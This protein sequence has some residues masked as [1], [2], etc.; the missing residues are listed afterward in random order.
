MDVKIRWQI[1]WSIWRWLW[2]KCDGEYGGQYGCDSVHVNPGSEFARA[3]FQ[4][5]AQES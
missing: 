5:T 2:Y 3:S 4:R 1:W